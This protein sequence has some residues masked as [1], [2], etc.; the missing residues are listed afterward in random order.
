M[1]GPLT[2]LE[3]AID[4]LIEEQAPVLDNMKKFETGL[5]TID[6]DFD[7]PDPEDLKKPLDGC[8]TMIDNFVGRAKK[9]V[10]EKLE[11][12]V[13]STLAGR[14]ATY[15]P[16]F[17]RFVVL[18]PLSVVLAVNVSLAV[19]QVYVTVKTEHEPAASK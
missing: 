14:I 1:G 19:L 15:G 11:E 10:P 5:R 3:T 16:T 6:P 9:E 17:N 8:E 13:Q 4:D 2:N 7:L 18:L 12:T